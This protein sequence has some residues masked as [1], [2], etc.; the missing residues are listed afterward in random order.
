[1]NAARRISTVP[2]VT[3]VRRGSG[4]RPATTV[5][6]AELEDPLNVEFIEELGRLGGR[7]VELAAVLNAIIDAQTRMRCA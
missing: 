7:C 6:G 3:S 4:V 1:M 2:S 5:R